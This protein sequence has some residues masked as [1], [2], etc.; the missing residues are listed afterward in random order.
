MKLANVLRGNCPSATLPVRLAVGAG[1]VSE[2]I[3][4]FSLHALGVGRFTKP[5]IPM[6]AVMAPLVGVVESAYRHGRR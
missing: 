5:G 3:Q 1:F 2:G 4:K 6:P